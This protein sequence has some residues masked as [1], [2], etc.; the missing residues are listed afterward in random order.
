M[1]K[2][3]LLAFF[4]LM[5]L[6]MLAICFWAGSQQNMVEYVSKELSDPWFMATLLDCYWGL[7][8]FSGWLVYQEKS[9]V[10]RV[11]W[12][13][14]IFCL[15]NIAVAIYGL[16]RVTRLPSDATFQDFLLSNTVP[17]SCSL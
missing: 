14:A 15:G 17:S 8:I 10:T 11:P 4:S 16:L 5:L 3:V 1:I 2:N 6:S 7:F 12:L 9:W 13:V